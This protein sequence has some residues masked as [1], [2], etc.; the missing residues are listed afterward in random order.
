MT[1]SFSPR[2]RGS[3]ATVVLTYGLFVL[4]MFVFQR[5]LTFA[6]S[7]AADTGVEY[8]ME[9][10]EVPTNDGL[11][12]QAWY[13]APPSDKAPVLVYFHGNAGNIGGRA[14]KYQAW[15]GQGAGVL[16]LEY[17]GYGRNLGAPS[18]E[19]FYKDARA[20][21]DYLMTQNIPG[22]RIILYGESIGTGV[23]S[24]MAE[25]REAGAL[26]LEA[27]F[28]SLADVGAEQY[29]YVA[30][31]YYLVRDRFDTLSRL[32]GITEPLLLFHGTADDVVPVHHSY[33]L[34]QAAHSPKELVTFEGYK[35]SNLPAKTLAEHGM[36]WYQKQ[37]ANASSSGAQ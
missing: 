22:N 17:R 23:A 2:L 35:H 6:P 9:D 34:E 13:S 16:A 30:G 4:C 37:Q 25:E 10:V 5:H 33:M 31:A 29:P 26:I 21:L 20:A 1:P 36:A 28:T 14:E 32:K 11:S 7:G 18:E 24:K 19:G 27:P 3:L 12:L 8:G 15:I